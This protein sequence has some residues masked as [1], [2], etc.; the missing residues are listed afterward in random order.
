MDSISAPA[1]KEKNASWESFQVSDDVITCAVFAPEVAH[2][3]PIPEEK[4]KYAAFGQVII[5]GGY[6]GE[7]KIYENIGVP[8]WL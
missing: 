7:V 8:R 1:A 5:T 4:G 3:K 2:F 6:Q